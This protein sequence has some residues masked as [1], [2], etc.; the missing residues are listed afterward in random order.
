[1]CIDKRY[2]VFN[3]DG[4]T[5]GVY[6]NYFTNQSSVVKT[7]TFSQL[8][9]KFNAPAPLEIDQKAKEFVEDLNSRVTLN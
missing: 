4:Y 2:L 7:F 8:F 5:L 9:G 1:M 6:V 3:I